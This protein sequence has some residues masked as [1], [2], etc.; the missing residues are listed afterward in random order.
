ME[1]EET[2]TASHSLRSRGKRSASSASRGP[3]TGTCRARVGGYVAPRGLSP[4]GIWEV[5]GAHFT[6]QRET[7][8]PRPQPRKRQFKGHGHTE[9]EGR[10]SLAQDAGWG[11]GRR[12]RDPGVAEKPAGARR[13][14]G[15]V[16]GW[17]RPA[18]R[19]RAQ[20]SAVPCRVQ[21]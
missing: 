2:G 1:G 15:V 17:P 21:T 9:G 6:S 11:G 16:A 18:R 14:G 8:R 3:R 13:G 19:P 12:L 5:K 7:H 10:G 4:C 20:P